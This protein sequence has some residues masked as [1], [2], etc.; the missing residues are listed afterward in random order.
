MATGMRKAGE[1]CWANMLT[2]QPA[3]AREFFSRL[4]GWT[5][6]E[7]P[8]LGH[9]VRVGGHDVGGIFDLE[10]HNTPPG[11]KPHIGGLIKVESADATG[12]K[13]AALGGTARPAFDIKDQGRMAVCTDPN[14]AELDVWEPRTFHGTD[15]DSSL[16]GAL[17][18]FETLTT[19]VGRATA[20]YSGL[21][22]WT[23]EVMSMPGYEYTVFKLGANYVAG[24]MQITSEM[25]NLRPHWGTYFSVDDADKAADEAVRLGAK[26]CV[27]VRDIPGVGRFCGITSPQG[28]TFYVIKYSR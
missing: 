21:F 24:L 20:F 7:I 12:E 2:P 28:V 14:G 11:L 17:C 8:G 9:G 18:W 19:D 13:V 23:P 3:E 25:G 5:Y 1:F 15:V 27:R 26:L 22:G 16:H 6:F 4:L 10:D